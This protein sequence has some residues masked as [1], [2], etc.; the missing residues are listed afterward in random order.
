MTEKLPGPERR[1]EAPV[2]GVQQVEEAASGLEISDLSEV[3][4]EEHFFGN[5]YVAG[6]E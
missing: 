1:L 6:R 2:T 5:I 4:E 3:D